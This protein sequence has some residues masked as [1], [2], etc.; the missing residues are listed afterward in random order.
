MGLLFGCVLKLFFLV[1]LVFIS[2]FGHSNLLKYIAASLEFVPVTLGAV[3]ITGPR[4]MEHFE[5]N[6][7]TIPIPNIS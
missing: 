4:N 1:L 7:I 2:V 6:G 5:S 3:G